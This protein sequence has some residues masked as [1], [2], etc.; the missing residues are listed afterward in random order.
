MEKKSLMPAPYAYSN[1]LQA[2][3]DKNF[4]AR[5][6]NFESAP[7]PLPDKAGN[8]QTHRMSA[9]FLGEKGTIPA[10]FPLVIERDG[11]LVMLSKPE[12]IDHARKTGEY[13]AFKDIKSA[14]Q[15]SRSYKTPEF[16]AFYNGS[17]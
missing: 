12:A 3:K 6:L 17:K 11:E 13:I 7:A 10:A 4:V 9:E 2:N 14:D 16:K 5:I 1:V 15:F 8:K